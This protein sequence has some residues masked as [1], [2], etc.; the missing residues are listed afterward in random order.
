MFDSSAAGVVSTCSEYPCYLAGG[1][2]DYRHWMLFWAFW[3]QCAALVGWLF[4]LG[5]AFSRMIVLPVM[6]MAPFSIL[7]LRWAWS[8]WKETIWKRSAF[9]LA[10]I[11]M[12]GWTMRDISID[13]I[14]FNKHNRWERVLVKEIQ[15]CEG[16]TWSIYPRIHNGPRSGTMVVKWYKDSPISKQKILVVFHG[17]GVTNGDY[18]CQLE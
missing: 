17:A 8:R 3:G 16:D 4:S 5:I 13:I 2:W 18:H 9:I 7:G 12:S 14:A 15:Q 6:I 1:K 10:L 11:A